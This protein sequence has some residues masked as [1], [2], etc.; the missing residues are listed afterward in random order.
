VYIFGYDGVAERIKFAY[1]VAQKGAGPDGQDLYVVNDPKPYNA[2]IAASVKITS[3][4]MICPPA[5]STCTVTELIDAA[6]SGFFAQVA[7]DAAGNLAVVTEK[8]GPPPSS[9]TRQK[10]SSPA[11]A[12]STSN[13]TSAPASPKAAAEPTSPP[14]PA[15]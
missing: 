6:S 2:G 5:G 15:G 7:I 4:G 13:S 3:G 14:S 12:G 1:A 10:P 8:G 9:D 11:T